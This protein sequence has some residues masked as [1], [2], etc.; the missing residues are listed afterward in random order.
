MLEAIKQRLKITGPWGVFLIALYFLI[1]GAL[2]LFIGS[3]MFYII[4]NKPYMSDMRFELVM[5]ALF[6]G[7]MI[8][9]HFVIYH[10]LRKLQDWGRI[11][12]IIYCIIGL[13]LTLFPFDYPAQ[14][15]GSGSISIL[16]SI[17]IDVLI[18]W[19]LSKKTV[20][21]YFHVKVPENMI[22]TYNINL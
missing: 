13:L 5:M 17:T 6:M 18:I 21:S 11:L 15:T 3:C 1:R 4:A 7:V 14:K 16:M 20:Q 12:A 8:L 9:I 2:Y 10:G 19:Y 22:S